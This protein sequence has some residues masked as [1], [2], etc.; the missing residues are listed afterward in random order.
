M[1]L[2]SFS[3][4]FAII[5]SLCRGLTG[6]A[7]VLASFLVQYREL[8]S[9]CTQRFPGKGGIS[10]AGASDILHRHVGAHGRTRT[11]SSCPFTLFSSSLFGPA[12]SCGRERENRSDKIC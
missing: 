1:P 2:R 3:F 7:V 9:L 11:R 4:H 6:A 5:L 10:H 12:T 8:G